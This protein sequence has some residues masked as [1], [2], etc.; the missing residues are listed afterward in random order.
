M[1]EKLQEIKNMD[2]NCGVFS[3]YDMDGKTTQEIFNQFVTKINDVIDAT[4]A[5]VTLIE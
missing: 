4:N 1:I 2:L 3:V 5:S